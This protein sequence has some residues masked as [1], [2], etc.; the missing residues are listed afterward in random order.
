MPTKLVCTSCGSRLAVVDVSC[1]ICGASVVRTVAPLASSSEEKE[2]HTIGQVFQQGTMP[3]EVCGYEN[4]AANNFCGSCGVPLRQ[5]AP[6]RQKDPIAVQQ[7]SKQKDRATAKRKKEG[8]QQERHTWIGNWR[9]VGLVVGV[10][11]VALILAVTATKNSSSSGKPHQL[12]SLNSQIL[13]EIDRLRKAVE[14]DPDDMASTLQLANVLHDADLKDQAISYYERYLA[15]NEKDADARV[16]M[17]IC[18]FELSQRDTTHARSFV[19][20]AIIEMEKALTYNPKHQLGCYN[21]GIVNL[22]VGN[23]ERS[24]EW[25]QRCVDVAPNTEIAHK[26]Q[27]LLAQHISSTLP[28][29]Q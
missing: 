10:A 20:T 29:T 28:R 13:E 25:F 16:D 4:P 7:T 9:I 14:S 22:S 5:S 11:A 3:C 8:R 18:Y 23:L 2:S 6:A 15:K 26:A 1:P 24:N 17:A 27:Q 21:L 19:S 12:D